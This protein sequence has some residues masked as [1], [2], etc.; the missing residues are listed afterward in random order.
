MTGGRMGSPT[1]ARWMPDGMP[2]E[3]LMGCR[4]GCP[5]GAKRGQTEFLTGAKRGPDGV[6]D[7]RIIYF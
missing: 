1:G 2:D 7:G 5:T 4:I 6:A 3:G